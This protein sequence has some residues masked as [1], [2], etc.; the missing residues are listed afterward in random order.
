MSVRIERVVRV[1][2]ID[3]WRAASCNELL[4]LGL[5]VL[6]RNTVFDVFY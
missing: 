6:Y 3:P 1:R 2:G 4:P 5:F